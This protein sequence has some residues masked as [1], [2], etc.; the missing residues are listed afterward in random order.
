MKPEGLI[1]SV[2]KPGG[3]TS[4]DVVNKIRSTLKWKS[5]GHAG[6]LDP[7]ATG[8][9]IVLCGAATARSAEFT[10]LGK[11]YL[12]SVRLGLVTDTDD[13]EGLV[14]ERRDVEPLDATT[15]ECCLRRFTGEIDQVPPRYS[16]VKV[17]GK[18]SYAM[19][20]RGKSVELAARRVTVYELTLRAFNGCDLILFVR[21]SAGTY[22][23]S[24][25]RDLGSALGC[26]ACLAAL[27]RTAVGPYESK[28]SLTLEEVVFRK[29][30][31]MAG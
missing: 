7:L 29:N 24:I 6:T 15:V 19:A 25:A 21:C 8:V 18:R 20:R 31:F 12:A 5:V 30:E 27:E 2:N 23:R 28:N 14:T 13:L 22:I 4:F 16:A 1:L 11:A 17:G 26:G 3:W 9:L 10:N